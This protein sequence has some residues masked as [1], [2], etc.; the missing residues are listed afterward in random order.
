MFWQT[1][2]ISIGI[3]AVLLAGVLS[4]YFKSPSEFSTSLM[5]LATLFAFG[6]GLVGFIQMRKHWF[7][8]IARTRDI[9]SIA[10]NLTRF[11]QV[12]PVRFRTKDV[13]N[14]SIYYPKVPRGWSYGQEA[15]SWLDGLMVATLVAL[16]A[17]M[18]VS[19][20]FFIAS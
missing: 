7:F 5:L 13:Q 12:Y 8:S 19:V 20:I 18:L 16:V 6:I 15:H 10:A 2:T 1:P 11:G 14:D 9:D 17:M 4:V 3:I